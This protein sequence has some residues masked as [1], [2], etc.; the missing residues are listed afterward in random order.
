MFEI[1]TT[2]LF[3]YLDSPADRDWHN[4]RNPIDFDLIERYFKSVKTYPGADINSD[5]NSCDRLVILLNLDFW[6][7]H[8]KNTS[9][10]EALKQERDLKIQNKVKQSSCGN[11]KRMR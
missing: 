10:P 1:L 8:G 4:V 2:C 9:Q 7:T 6:Q 11:T 3:I 5:R